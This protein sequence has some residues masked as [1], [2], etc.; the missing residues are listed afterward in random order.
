MNLYR[1]V[2]KPDYEEKIEKFRKEIHQLKNDSNVEGFTITNKMH[3][4]CDH[5]KDYVQLTGLGLGA[6]SDQN[7]EAMHQKL[8]SLLERSK[9]TMKLQKGERHADTLLKDRI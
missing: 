1:R 3:I 6:F 8:A 9:Y 4:I 7:V 2:V 5:V